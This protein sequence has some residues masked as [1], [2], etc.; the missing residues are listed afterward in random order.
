CSQEFRH[1][2][3]PC[4]SPT[5]GATTVRLRICATRVLGPTSARTDK[6]MLPTNRRTSAR[7]RSRAVVA[8]SS[9][10]AQDRPVLFFI[11]EDAT[12]A[13]HHAGERIFVDVNGKI[14][15]LTQEQIEAANQ[16]SAAGHD[17]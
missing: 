9:S 14:R 2:S 4:W 1:R 17:D 3:D 6:R 8:T 10:G 11:V 15:L 5:S 16:C 7:A 13:A 12:G